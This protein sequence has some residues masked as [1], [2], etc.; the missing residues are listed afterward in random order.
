MHFQLQISI[1][2]IWFESNF[3]HVILVLFSLFFLL[4][5]YP[6]LSVL[7]KDVLSNNKWEKKKRKKE[8]S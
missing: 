8:K 5:S 2:N 7:A 6:F 4:I 1:G 3:S